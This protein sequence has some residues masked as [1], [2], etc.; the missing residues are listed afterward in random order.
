MKKLLLL[1]LSRILF[2]LVV[3]PASA[4]TTA[5]SYTGR[6]TAG[7]LAASGNY[8]FSFALF[9]AETGGN[10]LAG[11]LG[12]NTVTVA[13]GLF[14][15]TLDFGPGVFT[16]PPRWLEV[17]VRAS[18]TQDFTLLNPRQGLNASPY[19][20]FANEAAAVAEGGIGSAAIQDASIV[21]T[22]ISSGQ[23]VKSI[24]GLTDAVTLQAGANISLTAND[25]NLVLSAS[26][27]AAGL[28]G[29]N[30]TSTYYTAGNVGIGTEMPVFALTLNG[31]PRW[32]SNG[33]G[34]SLELPNAAAI[35]WPANAG[36]Q[37]FGMGHTGGG[38]YLFRTASDPADTG[39]PANYDLQIDDSGQ[40]SVT[41]NL[42]VGGN[43]SAAGGFLG[44]SGPQPGI[45]F[46]DE[47]AILGDRWLTQLTSNTGNLEFFH[48]T[49]GL[50]IHPGSWGSAFLSITPGG[51]VG[52]GTSA[53]GAALDVRGPV[54]LQGPLTVGDN[55]SA[56][57]GCAD[58][59][60]GWSGRRGSPGR[61]LSDLGTTLEVN[62]CGD[63]ANTYVGGGNFSV[64][65]LTIRGG[66]DLA[67]PFPMR[68]EHLEKGAVVVIDRDHPGQL[69]RSD[70]AY[71]TC[72]AGIVS[73]AH[74]VNTGISLHQEGTLEE[75]QDIA[76]SGR[77]YVEADAGFGAINPGDLLT[78]SDTP[79]YAMKAADRS[80]A[81]GAVLGKAMSSLAEGK[82]MVL[83]LV[84]LQ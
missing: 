35:G 75:G 17:S 72:V 29:Q 59:L 65:S 68:E 77:V 70:H 23:V 42:D 39:S 61:A 5:F 49:P 58:L 27:G 83:V 63:W 28:W 38:F 44:L 74:G 56:T 48:W 1:W 52:I 51:E 10:Q 36:G 71:D 55:F 50:G 34:G 80:R 4:Q 33:W 46:S 76:L 13:D 41:G 81:P 18:G 15:V 57:I 82:G 40:V 24:N 45:Q 67:E 79:G 30:G 73:G 12:I 54:N 26:S 21:A 31:G 32:T 2:I 66:C 53:P 7:G 20:I 47:I 25:N 19:A 78:T 3:A 84:T 9:D 60:M 22:K 14:L 11:P 62:C 6:L 64:C 69:K 43:L 37:R 16:G 8:D